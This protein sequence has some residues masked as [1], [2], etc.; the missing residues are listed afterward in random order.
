MDSGFGQKEKAEEVKR[1]VRIAAARRRGSLPMD[2]LEPIATEADKDAGP[3]LDS[4]L[5]WRTST[6]M[7]PSTEPTSSIAHHDSWNRLDRL[8]IINSFDGKPEDSELDRRFIMFYF[9]HFFPFLFPFYKPLLLE[10]GRSSL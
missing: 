5:S 9:D 8:S 2:V 3:T 6:H 7:R 10:G 4:S 1:E